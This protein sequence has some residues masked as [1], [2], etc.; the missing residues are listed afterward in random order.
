[1]SLEGNPCFFP[2]PIT[3]GSAV[4]LGTVFAVCILTNLL[5][6][7]Y[8]LVLDG[9]SGHER[10]DFYVVIFFENGFLCDY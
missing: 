6:E 10:V 4:F 3:E 5:K 1:M 7:I 8:I 9:Q 2:Y